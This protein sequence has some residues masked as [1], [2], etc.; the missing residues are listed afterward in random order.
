MPINRKLAR[1]LIK[2]YGWGK[3]REIYH[4]MEADGKPAFIKGMK[5][6]ESKGEIQK[7]FPRKSRRKKK[8]K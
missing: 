3:A 2:H 6:A 5:T 8:S 4:K 1:A 7:S